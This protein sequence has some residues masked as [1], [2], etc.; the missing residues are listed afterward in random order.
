MEETTTTANINTILASSNKLSDL[1]NKT[2]EIGD[3][4]T[5]YKFMAPDAQTGGELP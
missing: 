4:L 1:I 3:T 2:I 5:R